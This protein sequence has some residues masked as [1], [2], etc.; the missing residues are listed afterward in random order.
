[1]KHSKSNLYSV[2]LI[3][4]LFICSCQKEPEADIEPQEESILK[5]Y[6][7]STTGYKDG[8]ALEAQ[9]ENPTLL[10][11]GP[12]KSL[13]VVESR[14]PESIYPGY[15]IRKITPSGIVTTFFDAKT[16]SHGVSNIS[17]IAIEKN[18]CVLISDGN[19][20]KRIS[21]D[22]NLVTVV[23]G[24]GTSLVMKDGVA[25][26]AT[27]YQPHG[28]VI[29]KN[30][31]VYIMDT[32]NNAVRILSNGKVST[33]AG[34]D[35]TFDPQFD[36]ETGVIGPEPKDGTGSQAEFNNPEFITLDP[37]GNIYVSG[38]YGPSIRKIT[39]KGVVTTIKRGPWWETDFF[40]TVRGITIHKDQIYYNDT[41]ARYVRATYTFK[42]NS[43]SLLTNQT[44]NF[45]SNIWDTDTHGDGGLPPVTTDGLNFPMGMAVVDNILYICNNGEN[46]IRKMELN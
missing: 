33:L 1:M 38:G 29:D 3:C 24:D 21:S 43:L 10:A 8:P 19:Q 42:L 41:D 11:V 36:S 39:Q 32:G 37:S 20:I 25:L 31:C 16:S 18:G 46:R 28:L 22:G 30:G 4:L 45:V 5:V 44:T 23:A 7:G 17:G 26:K 27:F 9:F 6:A 2:L 13:F 34:G 15:R 14:R 35:R 12:D 40:M